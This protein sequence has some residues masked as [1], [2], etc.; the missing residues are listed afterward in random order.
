MYLP[1]MKYKCPPPL[2]SPQNVSPTYTVVLPFPKN[3]FVNE[4][5]CA[6]MYVFLPLLYQFNECQYEFL[7]VSIITILWVPVSMFCVSIIAA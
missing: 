7:C 5:R 2:P 6:G 1:L 3:Q 4:L